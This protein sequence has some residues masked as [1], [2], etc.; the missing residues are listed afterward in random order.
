VTEEWIQRYNGPADSLDEAA[1]I[2]VDAGGNVYVTGTSH[3]P[4]SGLDY[5]TIKYNNS[6][7]EQWRAHYTGVAEQEDRATALAVDA[8][9]NVY[10]TGQSAGDGTTGTDFAT[11]KYNAAGV[12]QWVTRYYSPVAYGNDGA[13]VIAVDGSGNVFVTGYSVGVGSGNDYAT[14]KYNTA[15]VQQWVMRY[16]GDGNNADEPRSLAVDGSGNVYVTGHSVGVNYDYATI[17]YSN[18]GA[19]QWVARYNG[20][21]DNEDKATALA[22]DGSGNVFV[23]G[24]S[25]FNAS[26]YATIKYNTSGV[27]QWVSQYYGPVSL[28]GEARAV[29]LDGSGN[30]YVT[31]AC[32]GNNPGTTFDY[33]TVK[34]NA[35]GVQQWAALYNGPGNNQDQAKAIAV[36][37]SGNVYVTGFSPSASGN[38]LT[39]DYATLK[40]NAG[41]VEQWVA[42]YN[43]PGGTV[44]IATGIALDAGGNVYVTGLSNTRSDNSI[45]GND[46]AT[47]KYSQAAPDTTPPACTIGAVVVASPTR[48]YVPITLTDSG[49]GVAGVKLTTNSSN[50][51]LEWDGPGG[52]VTAPINTLITISPASPSITVRAVKLN[53]ALKA[54][55]ELRVADA[56]GNFVVCDPVIAN[57][58]VKNGR[59]PLI[60][61]FTGIPHAERYVT[62][63]NGAP[64]LTQ[65][66][67]S[68][69]GRVVSQGRLTDG[70]TVS[71]DIAH[72]LR[73]GNRNVVRIAARGPK[74]ATAVLTI[75][76]VA[77]SAS[78][79]HT[80][81]GVNR[82]FSH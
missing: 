36:D 52:L 5:T 26:G 29:T 38:G 43:G 61:T 54:R 28:G 9:G 57:L 1:A 32:R 76:D 35:A 34:Y 74:G 71:L 50:C 66:T 22:V 79:V 64:G 15:G 41:G 48:V 13:S 56:A 49:S 47:I 72:W 31:G 65:A 70:Q 33:G 8:G 11:V 62:L 24:W 20:P 60:R 80:Q 42:R 81:G 14:V 7:V 73:S 12:E 37:G 67:L 44:D 19:Q 53:T 77:P 10:V 46:Y 25:W 40:Y 23:T 51:Q 3:R 2:K 39:A 58:E 68:V 21:G 78:A 18:G 17:K 4:A 69:N 55:V 27:E 63:Q 82:E 59:A 6:G 45:I 16:N 75:G 30:V